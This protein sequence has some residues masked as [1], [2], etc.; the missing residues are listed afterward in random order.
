LISINTI[1]LYVCP[2]EF[3]EILL[4]LAYTQGLIDSKR[5]MCATLV[6]DHVILYTT[7]HTLLKAQ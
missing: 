7:S 1:C 2:T 5:S 3:S 6:G 4:R